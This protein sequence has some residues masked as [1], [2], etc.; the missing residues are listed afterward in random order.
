MITK[1]L[2]LNNRRSSPLAGL[3]NVNSIGVVGHSLGAITTLGV[4]DNSCCQD[5][6]ISAAVTI[7]GLELPVPGGTYFVGN[8]APLLLI[9]GTADQTIA[10]PRARR[11]LPTPKLP[12]SS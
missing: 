2:E 9:H 4:A 7:A 3:I 11:S 8:D 1:V 10:S 6:R 5:S 12:S